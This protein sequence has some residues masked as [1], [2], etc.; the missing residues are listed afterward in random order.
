MD[1]VRSSGSGD[2]EGR[3]VIGLRQEKSGRC[4]EKVGTGN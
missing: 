2:K 4:P 3:E 1:W